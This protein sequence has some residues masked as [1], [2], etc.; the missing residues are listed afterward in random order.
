MRFRLQCDG[1]VQL[2]VGQAARGPWALTDP[3][4][5]DT[6]DQS[7]GPIALPSLG[8]SR[9]DPA[10]ARGPRRRVIPVRP[11]ALVSDRDDAIRF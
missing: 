3:R 8:S 11:S 7:A 5:L 6:M 2:Q 1:S 10:A 4:L 9:V